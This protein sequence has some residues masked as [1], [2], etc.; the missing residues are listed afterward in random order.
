MLR[1][2]LQATK[3]SNDLPTGDDYDFYSTYN[4]V[5]NIMDLEARRLLQL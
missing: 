4:S 3:A 5:R 2:V 1:T